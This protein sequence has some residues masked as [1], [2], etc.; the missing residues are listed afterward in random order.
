ML[1]TEDRDKIFGIAVTDEMMCLRATSKPLGIF[2]SRNAN[3]TTVVV[4]SPTE[5]DAFHNGPIVLGADE[6]DRFRDVLADGR[7]P[8]AAPPAARL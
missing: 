6:F 3:A 8:L 1:A 2:A 4:A 5:L 7:R